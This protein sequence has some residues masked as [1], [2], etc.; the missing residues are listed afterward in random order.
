M[1]E[2]YV[3]TEYRNQGIYNGNPALQ[4]LLKRVQG[5]VDAGV[6]HGDVFAISTFLWTFGHGAVSLMIGFRT[7]LSAVVRLYRPRY[8][9]SMA[10]IANLTAKPA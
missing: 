6:L 8:E 4:L 1:T 9:A 2:R 5:C 10:G 7:T 3:D